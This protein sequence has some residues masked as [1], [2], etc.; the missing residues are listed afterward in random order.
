MRKCFRVLIMV[1]SAAMITGLVADVAPPGARAAAASPTITITLDPGAQVDAATLATVVQQYLNTA[2]LGDAVNR[3]DTSTYV[4][5]PGFNNTVNGSPF[6]GTVSATSDGTGLTATVSAGDAPTNPGSAFWKLPVSGLLGALSANVLRGLCVFGTLQFILPATPP[7]IVRGLG[8]S[9]GFL[10]QFFANLFTGL[11]YQGFNGPQD[12]SPLVQKVLQGIG[13]ALGTAS[14]EVHILED[15]GNWL[16][17]MVPGLQAIPGNLLFPAPV[18]NAVSTAAT[19]L[20]DLGH[21]LNA[22]QGT[23][24]AAGASASSPPCDIYGYDGTPCVDAYSTTRSLY[25]T[26]DGPLYELTRAL[27]GATTDV[28]PLFAGGPADATAQD[29]FCGSSPCKITKVFDQSPDWDDVTPGPE[30]GAAPAD[31][32]ADAASLPVRVGSDQ[33]YGLDISGGIGY[34]DNAADNIAMG[35]DPEGMYMVA[36]GTHVNSKCC[37]DFGNAET[38]STDKGPGHMDALNL[39][40]NCYTGS[41]SGDG[42]WVAADLEDGLYQGGGDGS[43]PNNTGNSSDF[44]TAMM[45]NDGT[46]NFALE[47]GDAQGGGLSTWYDGPLPNPPGKVYSPMRK[48]GA[49]TLGVGG[50]NSNGGIGSFFEGAMTAGYPSDAADDLIQQNIVQAHYNGNSDGIEATSQVAG[51]A[52]VHSAGAP[53]TSPGG[54]TSV[55]TVDAQNGH[56]QETYLTTIGAKWKTQDLSATG[57]TLPGTPPVKPD[58]TPVAIVHDG[59]TSV[60][61]IDAANNHLQETY[62]PFI[63][64]SWKTQDLSATGGTLPGTPPSKVTP[65]ALYHDGYTSVYTID[66]S[67]GHLRETFLTGLGAKWQTQDLTAKTSASGAPSAQPG[68]APVA[69]Y[70]DGYV[71][72]FTVGV[73]HDIWETYLQAIGDSWAAHDLTKISNGPQT[74]TTLTAVYHD[75]YTS[76]YAAGD[77]LR[78]LWELYLPYI[79]ATWKAQDLSTTGGTLPDTP[80]VAPGTAPVALFHTGYTSVYTVDQGSMDLQE[81]YLPGDGFPGDSWHTQDLSTNPSTNTP[82][83]TETP[84]V[85]VHPDPSGALTWTS[86]FTINHLDNDLQETYLPAIGDNWTTQD[87]NY[88]A[89]APPVMPTAPTTATWSVANDG[90]TYV[91]TGNINGDLMV[92]Y[93]PAMGAAWQTEDLTNAGQAPR[94]A[95]QTW[96]VAVAWNGHVTVFTVG[97]AQGHLWQTTLNANGGTWTG[98]DLT[99]KTGGP[100]TGVTPTAVFHGGYLSA[101]TVD[102]SFND[103]NPGDL[104]ETYLPYGTTTWKTQDLSTAPTKAP[105]VA[106][107]TSPVALYHDGFTSVFTADYDSRYYANDLQETYLTAIGN[108]WQ[109]QDLT[110]LANGIPMAPKATPAAVYHSGYVSVFSAD[111]ATDDNGDSDLE[112]T[113]LT[114]IGDKWN[115]QDLTEK[116]GAPEVLTVISGGLPPGPSEEN[117]ASYIAAVYHSGYT[118]VHTVDG[119][120]NHMQ[121]TF[122]PAMSDGWLHQDLTA[123][124]P[125]HP[126]TGSSAPLSAL[127]HYDP[128]GGLT[129]TS[130]FSYNL[131]GS[132]EETWLPKIGD[133]WS[134]QKLPNR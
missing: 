9:C 20:T 62:L 70:H 121:E 90:Y 48:E 78:H 72:V 69:L 83:T 101:Y 52:V 60:Y 126:T 7:W 98:I 113:Y 131:D 2:N 31:N 96:P 39:G 56:L 21:D 75:G 32:P 18:Q 118:S 25:S 23:V 84:I 81:T 100:P 120:N 115:S 110:H 12:V 46:S 5:A 33:V 41:C 11:I 94:L 53:S 73:G 80:P 16:L 95:G 106:A 67:N 64:A 50:D 111:W 13:T 4:D 63:G 66:A 134:T 79:G 3:L 68:T 128:H 119:S 28:Y 35:D 123:V 74:A 40:T 92:S 17:A 43:N 105:Q 30:G 36:S 42:P 99:A 107:D 88:Y 37:F 125:D 71:S 44:V 109:T 91:F 55:Y 108:D 129:W 49:V 1:V 116:Y 114:A 14:W 93:L 117:V 112:E 124:T 6:S 97:N 58:T 59:Y 38:S 34:R 26:Y 65:T 57:G 86:V 132:L 85:V 10:G 61:T 15:I 45:E 19:E 77:P 76:V 133:G 104:Q 87:L 47:G 27:D 24:T 127:V 130:V 22:E 89:Q 29:S 82:P 103:L 51:E 8:A 122:L 102:D 54:Y